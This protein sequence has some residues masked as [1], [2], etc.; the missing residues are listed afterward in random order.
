[1]GYSDVL[2]TDGGDSDSVGLLRNELLEQ[3]STSSVWGRARLVA[4]MTLVL[5]TTNVMTYHLASQ[6]YD[7][8][9]SSFL[10]WRGTPNSFC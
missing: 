5:C 4:T 3:R 8:G 1:M 6:H 7:H 2:C 10:Q 9:S